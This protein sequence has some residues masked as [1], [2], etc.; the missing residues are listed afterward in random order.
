MKDGL[1][2]RPS[3][4]RPLSILPKKSPAGSESRSMLPTSSHIHMQPATGGKPAESNNL[5]N[6]AFACY[7]P[8]IKELT[9]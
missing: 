7:L 8:V 1:S 6:P 9:A 2:P 3:S 5:F 4:R